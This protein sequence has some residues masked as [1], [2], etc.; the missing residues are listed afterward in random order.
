MSVTETITGTQF[1]RGSRLYTAA[2]VDGQ[3]WVSPGWDSKGPHL[4]SRTCRRIPIEAAW[5][6]ARQKP[7]GL[8][9]VALGAIDITERET[10]VGGGA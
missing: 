6:E 5:T 10:R 9:A 1:S 4:C 7:R 3:L 8:V 2:I